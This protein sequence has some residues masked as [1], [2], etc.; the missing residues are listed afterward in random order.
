MLELTIETENDAFADNPCDELARILRNLADKIKGCQ[1]SDYPQLII[2]DINGN[3][4]GMLTL[5]ED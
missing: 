5:T 3:N 4:C 1:L 2:R